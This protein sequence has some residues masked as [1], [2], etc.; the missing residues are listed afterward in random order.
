[1]GVQVEPW[2]TEYSRW[3]APSVTGDEQPT[4]IYTSN[5]LTSAFIKRSITL[6]PVYHIWRIYFLLRVF[7]SLFYTCF[8]CSSKQQTTSLK[9]IQRRALQI[10]AGNIP[11]GE[12]CSLFK[13]SSLSERPDSLFRQIGSHSHILHYLLPAQR[14][15]GLTGR[16]RSRN[17]YPTVHARTNRF[18]NS[19]IPY[20]IANYQ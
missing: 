2:S 7:F 1:M 11:Y 19:F 5:R 10:I 3:T 13:L 9:D 15:D 14:V 12:A 8:L 4:L 16:L 20:T 17:K 6:H 18:E